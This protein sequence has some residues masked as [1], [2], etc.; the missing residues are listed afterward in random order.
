MGAAWLLLLLLLAVQQPAHGVLGE[1]TPVQTDVGPDK[2]TSCTNTRCPE[3]W[4]SGS[5]ISGPA[6]SD[7]CLAMATCVRDVLPGCTSYKDDSD[8]DWGGMCADAIAGFD[9]NRTLP[10]NVGSSSHPIYYFKPAAKKHGT[11]VLYL[12]PSGNL[13]TS[14]Q[15]GRY[16]YFL[17]QYL[18]AQGIGVLALQVPDPTS[19]IWDHVPAH[20]TSSPYD[21][22]CHNITCKRL[23]R[24]RTVPHPSHAIWPTVR[25]LSRLTG[26]PRGF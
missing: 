4:A 8:A 3:D 6:G 12:P 13:P 10:N 23:R 15:Q 5:T 2:Q 1:S 9:K 11:V 22:D 25:D 20:N 21:Y 18:K 16:E 17:F 7:P 14:S 26:N 24:M 19:D